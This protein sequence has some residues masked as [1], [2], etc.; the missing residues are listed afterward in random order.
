VLSG[1]R[2]TVPGPCIRKNRENVPGAVTA[3][4]SNSR[5]V[6]NL[7][8]MLLPDGLAGA[9]RLE[10]TICRNTPLD[11]GVDMHVDEQVQHD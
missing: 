9:P 3:G 10:A 5:E 8:A 11:L 6:M 4:Y 2:H 7:A 1:R